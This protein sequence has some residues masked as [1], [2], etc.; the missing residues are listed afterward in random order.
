MLSVDEVRQKLREECQRAGSENAWA[1]ANGLSQ[2]YVY[3]TIRGERE[4][5]PKILRAL[6]LERVVN[7]R[8][9]QS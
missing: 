3:D 7:Y 6:K 2:A 1:K 8:R 9:A 4:P 5:G